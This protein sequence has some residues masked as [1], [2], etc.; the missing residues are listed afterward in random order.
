MKSLVIALTVTIALYV[1]F[2][3]AFQVS[4]PHGALG[5]ALGW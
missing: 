5:A 1:V 4:L 2:E 3:R